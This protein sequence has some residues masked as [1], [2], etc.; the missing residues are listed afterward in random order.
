MTR[1]SP[2]AYDTAP[3]RLKAGLEEELRLR[4]RLTNLK[5]I[6]ARSPVALRVYGEWFALKDALN[7]RLSDRAIFIFS[8]AIAK[9]QRSEIP[10]G[11]FRRA[12]SQSGF[13]PDRLELSGEEELL[14]E[15]GSVLGSD[16]N[17]VSDGLWLRLAEHYDDTVLVDLAAFAGIMVATTVFANIVQA[18]ADDDVVPFLE[19]RP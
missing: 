16:A 1:L 19:T 7:A 9:A 12:L 18:E 8:L 3:E 15:F 17:A 14:Q 11:F 5:L 4:G 10:V 6:Q 2:I 13:D